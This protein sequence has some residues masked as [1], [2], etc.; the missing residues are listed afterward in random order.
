MAESAPASVARS[1]LLMSVATLG[2]RAT[3]LVRTWAMAF[4]LGNTL[5]T[6]AYQVANNMPNVIYEL[7]VGGIMGAAFIPVYLLQKEKLG[8][9]GG[10][11]F[12][13]NI[14]N[15]TIIVLGVL[16]VL[17]TVFAPQV[18]ATQTFTV[19]NTAEV[20]EYAITFFRIFA[21]Q[22]LFYGIGGVMTG[23]LNA[24]RIYFLPSIAPA[25]NNVIVIVSFFSYIPL[26]AVDPE[27]AL[28]V[29]AVGTTLGVVAQFA[30]Q[31]PALVKMGYRF[32]LKIDLHD[33][34]LKEALKIA[35][36]TFVYIVG[37]MVSFSCRNAFSLQA[38]DTGPSTLLYAW[39]W[40]Q[41]PHGVVAVS[42]SRALFTEMSEAVA[43]EDWGALRAHVRT[44]IAGTLL[45]IIPLAGIMGALA[46]PLMQLFQAGAFNAEDVAYVASILALWMVSLPFYSVLMYLYNVFA[47]M[48]KFLVFA[49]V[50]TIMVVVQCG[51]YAV[52]C[53]PELL[54]LAGVPVAD[55]V[56]YGGCCIIMIVI[57]RRRI[58]SF[59][60]GSILSMAVRVVVATAVGV[61]VSW[62]TSTVLPFG[63][64][65][66]ASGFAKLV[67]CGGLG[68]VIT[69][70][71][72]ALF[73][74]PEMHYVTDLLAKVGRKLTRRGG[75]P[76]AGDEPIEAAVVAAGSAGSGAHGAEPGRT[77][78][79]PRGKHAR[80]DHWL[81]EPDESDGAPSL[82]PDAT[83]AIMARARHVAPAGGPSP[84]APSPDATG[85]I[86]ERAR[87]VRQPEPA[88]EPLPPDATGAI[89]KRARHIKK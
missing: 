42:L 53:R 20:T 89:M 64:S 29:L 26:S 70:G 58:G 6:S 39:T 1:T 73:R 49:V 8:P 69:F 5:F 59:E 15:L 31:I 45:L 72:C 71:L 27:L 44:G 62:G 36:P 87:H 10:N 77:R 63:D 35:L 2:S 68:L 79:L 52:L 17:A 81:D 4:A 9:E 30:I 33:P 23:I 86:M 22:I 66:M 76:D 18:I 38:G 65:G 47:S 32:M 25:L 24:N 50:S 51:L 82:P 34:A 21:F 41:L 40:Y 61:G 60:L 13:S 12:A 43:R 48:R 3:G 7:V 83:G 46:T 84:A 11:R 14:L 28:I 57:L 54:G 85:A 75:A 80:I 74:V 67:V 78:E 56:Y 55:L 16:S 19:G 88:P 37:T